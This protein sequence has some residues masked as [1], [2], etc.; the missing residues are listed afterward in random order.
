MRLHCY[1]IATLYT[2]AAKTSHNTS[3]S[4]Y[5]VRVMVHC[6]MGS[7]V[8]YGVRDGHGQRRSFFR[9]PDLLLLNLRKI[10]HLWRTINATR[11]AEPA[12][13]FPQMSQKRKKKQERVPRSGTFGALRTWNSKHG[14]LKGRLSSFGVNSTRSKQN[15]LR[16][17]F[18]SWTFILN[19]SDCHE[20]PGPEMQARRTEP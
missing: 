5:R 9:P 17:C 7:V 12:L 6:I 3:V 19:L 4:A 15:V 14:N 16:K 10:F 8:W 2:S 18:S 11:S 20:K 1:H 13:H